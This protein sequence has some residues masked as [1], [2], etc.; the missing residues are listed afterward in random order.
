M[1]INELVIHGWDMRSRLEKSP[2]LSEEVLPL[3]T[4]RV[5]W[6]FRGSRPAGFLFGSNIPADK[7]Y[8][9]NLTGIAS[10]R[11]DIVVEGDTCRIEAPSRSE[12]NASLECDT[13]TFVLLMN[14]RLTLADLS[15][16]A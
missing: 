11:L 5:K 8:R 15:Q 2:K 3:L 9:F 4:E 7:R 14:R 6:L 1:T 16:T 13:Q 12:A 10:D